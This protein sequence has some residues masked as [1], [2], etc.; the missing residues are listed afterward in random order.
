MRGTSQAFLAQIPTDVTGGVKYELAPVVP[1]P[2]GNASIMPV[3]PVLEPVEEITAED[4]PP[5]VSSG[6]QDMCDMS[7]STACFSDRKAI[8]TPPSTPHGLVGRW[9]FDEA[10]ALDS[11]GSGNHAFTELTHGPSPAG[12]GHSSVFHKTFVAV[13]NSPSLQFAST[14]SVTFWIYV[15]EDD[16]GLAAEDSPQWCPLVRKGVHAPAAREFESSP[17]ILYAPSSGQLR[18]SVTTA[19]HRTSVDGEYVDSNA[20]LPPNRWAHVAV[21]HH[22]TKLLLYVNG[23][24]DAVNAVAGDVLPNKWPLYIGGDPFA[25]EQCAHT[26]YVD[27]VS[28]YNRAVAPHELQAEAA[29]ALG[30]TDPSFVHLGCKSCSIAAAATSCPAT[31]HICTSLELH[32][33]A[34]QVAR[35][36]GWLAAGGHVWTF[37]AM[38]QNANGVPNQEQQTSVGFGIPVVGLGLCCDG[39]A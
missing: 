35:S 36:L 27:D 24:L 12:H 3:A 28:V 8:L 1:M 34:Y 5:I 6:D 17:A 18:A 19:T 37:A 22:G 38:K 2:V 4:L 14:F 31:R 29:P 9:T 39:Y 33:G 7:G 32:T 26:T 11:S 13:P 30:G 16:D 25:A 15:V 21:V 23:I 10:T 20:R